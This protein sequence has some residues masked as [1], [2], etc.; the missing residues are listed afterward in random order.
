MYFSEEHDLFRQTVRSFVEKE[1]NPYV[2][3]WEEEGIF[4]AHKLFKR[5]G[6]WAFWG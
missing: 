2:D 4:P 1:I 5:W 6:I 3:E